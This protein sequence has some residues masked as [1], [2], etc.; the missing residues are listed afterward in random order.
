MTIMT[1]IRNAEGAVINIGP[2]DYMIEGREDGDIVHNP[3]P[4]GAY[5]DQAEIVERADGGLE[6]A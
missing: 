1:I 5:E 3:L 4:D 6:A 2:W